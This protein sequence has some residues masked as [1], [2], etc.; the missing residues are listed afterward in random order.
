MGIGVGVAGAGVLAISYFYDDD[1]HAKVG[2]S[3][4]KFLS[5]CNILVFGGS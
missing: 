4:H 3:Y 5:Q 1:R 2:N